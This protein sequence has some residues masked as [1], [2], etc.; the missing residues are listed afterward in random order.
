MGMNMS[1]KLSLLLLG[2]TCTTALIAADL[3]R[4]TA[5]LLSCSSPQQPARVSDEEAMSKVLK[6]LPVKGGSQSFG[7]L[8]AMHEDYIRQFQTAPGFGSSRMFRLPLLNEITMPGYTYTIKLPDLISLENEP[9]VYRS[10]E[11]NIVG[12][13]VLTNRATKP[14]LPKRETTLAEANAIMKLRRGENMVIVKS[15]VLPVGTPEFSPASPS[16]L[17]TSPQPATSVVSRA[18]PRIAPVRPARS[19]PPAVPLLM[20]VDNRIPGLLAVGALRAGK[21]CADCH[22]CEEGTL[23][24]AF[25]YQLI[26]RPSTNTP[27]P[28]IARNKVGAPIISGQP[29]IPVVQKPQPPRQQG[30]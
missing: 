1:T 7:S 24:G 6:A 3:H 27:I 14:H 26:P 9:V 25:S 11:I 29:G 8:D 18:T 22:G 20:Q 23:L 19:V 30:N 4:A 16:P 5:I 13:N 10:S 17:P 21:A 12:M 2:F 28:F 15:L